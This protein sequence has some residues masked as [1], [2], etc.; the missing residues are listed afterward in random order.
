MITKSAITVTAEVPAAFHNMSEY[1]GHIMISCGRTL[2]YDVP[3]EAKF[4]EKL[5]A[6]MWGEL[7]RSGKKSVSGD[8][9]D[10]DV[11]WA[12]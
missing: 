1:V 4:A 3:G 10:I 2:D 6:A 7:V 8:E 11:D 5:Q 9:I 12:D